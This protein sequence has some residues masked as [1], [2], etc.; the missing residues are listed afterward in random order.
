MT[1]LILFR[2]LQRWFAVA[3]FL[4]EGSQRCCPVLS[5]GF[6]SITTDCSVLSCWVFSWKKLDWGLVCLSPRSY[7]GLPRSIIHRFVSFPLLRRPSFVNVP[8]WVAS[9]VRIFEA[10]YNGSPRSILFFSFRTPGA[11]TFIAFLPPMGFSDAEDDRVKDAT[12][13]RLIIGL[14]FAVTLSSPESCC[15][16][17]AIF[18]AQHKL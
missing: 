16:L 8:P 18:S 10:D 9:W 6:S 4:L 7:N 3:L 12:A 2:R 5:R 13:T 14:D 11:L 17:F 15:T 1:S